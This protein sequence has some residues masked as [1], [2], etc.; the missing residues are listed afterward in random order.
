M[1]NDSDWMDALRYLMGAPVMKQEEFDGPF[2]TLSEQE[3]ADLQESWVGNMPV[4]PV[5]IDFIPVIIDMD[6]LK[7]ED[8]CWHEPAEYLGLREAFTYCRKCDKRL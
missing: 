4:M 2:V 3:I 5:G 1:K 6:K 7:A 8:T